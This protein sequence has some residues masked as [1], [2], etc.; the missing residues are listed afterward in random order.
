M[1][2][3]FT[4]KE[5]YIALL[6]ALAVMARRVCAVRA[7]LRKLV[8]KQK[9]SLNC[10]SKIVKIFHCSYTSVGS[11]YASC[12]CNYFCGLTFLLF[13]NAE[14]LEVNRQKV[15]AGW[16]QTAVKPH[17]GVLTSNGRQ[18]WLWACFKNHFPVKKHHKYTKRNNITKQISASL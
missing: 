13:L 4:P 5:Q 17:S 7:I 15:V 18:L 12:L 6:F 14:P 11:R 2:S 1:H 9:R 8:C 10:A 3:K 16:Q